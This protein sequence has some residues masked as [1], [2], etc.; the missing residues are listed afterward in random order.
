MTRLEVRGSG[1]GHPELRIPRIEG[2]NGRGLWL[3]EHLADDWGVVE[4]RVGKTVWTVFKVTDVP[5]GAA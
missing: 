3:V 5:D 4:H 2:S 1:D